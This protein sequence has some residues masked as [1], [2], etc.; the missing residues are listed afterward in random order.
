MERQAL[1]GI[2]T[3]Q[4]LEGGGREGHEADEEAV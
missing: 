2:V 3:E 4:G 1:A